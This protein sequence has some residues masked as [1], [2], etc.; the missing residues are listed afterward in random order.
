MNNTKRTLPKWC[1]DAKKALID[2]DMSVTDLARELDYSR[3]HISAVINDTVRSPNT[4]AAIC[5]HLEISAS[6]A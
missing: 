5:T 3:E 6:I 4:Q 1:K 2:R